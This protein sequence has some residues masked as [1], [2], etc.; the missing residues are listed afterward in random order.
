MIYKH[1]SSYNITAAAIIIGSEIL[2]GNIQDQN[3]FILSNMLFNRGISL[4]KIEII[5]DNVLQIA[6]SIKHLSSKF[7]YIFTS[8]GIGPTHDDKTY[9]SISKAF[10][11]KLQYKKHIL[12]QIAKFHNINYKNIITNNIQKKMFTF[13]NT[14]KIITHKSLLLPLIIVKNVY[15]LPG[16]P[17]L[18]IKFT[19]I[20]KY[21]FYGLQQQKIVIYTHKSESQ[22]AKKLTQIQ[23]KYNYINIG[24]YPQYNNKNYKVLITL[25]CNA[26]INI[27]KIIY[28]IKYIVNGFTNI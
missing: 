20:I 17:A 25:E 28:K 15:I 4:N 24:S 22:F 12:Q 11:L 14:C 10:N 21:H 9:Y 19:N 13:P 3:I 18:F 26:N 27:K 1:L 7:N 23:K 2:T 6:N 8:G 16:V 5:K